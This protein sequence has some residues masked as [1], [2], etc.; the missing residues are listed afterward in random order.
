MNS[1]SKPLVSPQYSGRHGRGRLIASPAG[2]AASGT[3]VFL[4]LIGG[5]QRLT[6]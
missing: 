3:P 2:A 5:V 4:F 1:K 6:S